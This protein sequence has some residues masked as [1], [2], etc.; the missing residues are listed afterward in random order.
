MGAAG[1]FFFA[2]PDRALGSWVVV[3]AAERS[4]GQPIPSLSGL[5]RVPT[6]IGSA[7]ARRAWAANRADALARTS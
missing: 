2:V 4:A 7:W 1:S 3:P 6:G 5:E